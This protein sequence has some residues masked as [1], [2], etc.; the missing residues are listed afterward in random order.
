M[1]R[2]FVCSVGCC[3]KECRMNG[4]EFLYSGRH[5][6]NDPKKPLTVDKESADCTKYQAPSRSRVDM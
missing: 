5:T 4:I 2:L 1:T 3:H 6:L